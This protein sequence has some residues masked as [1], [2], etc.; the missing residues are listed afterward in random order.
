MHNQGV[1]EQYMQAVLEYV[2]RLILT[3]RQADD[4]F[5]RQHN[6]QHFVALLRDEH[7]R[8]QP[9]KLQLLK[10]MALLFYETDSHGLQSLALEQLESLLFE[11]RQVVAELCHVH[12]LTDLREVEL[13]RVLAAKYRRLEYYV[14]SSEVWTEE[15]RRGAAEVKAAA[16][17]TG[18]VNALIAYMFEHNCYSEHYNASRIDF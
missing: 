16:V 17:F 10:R 15:I 4:S 14:D 5:I 9:L 3:H 7:A 8:H 11:G 6:S 12:L 1:A 2:N 18:L 13:F